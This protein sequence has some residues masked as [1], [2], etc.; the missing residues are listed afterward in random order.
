M[1]LLTHFK[2]IGVENLLC[3]G[4]PASPVSAGLVV[5][6]VVLAPHWWR[7]VLP[8]FRLPFFPLQ[9][10]GHDICHFRAHCYLEKPCG[11]FWERMPKENKASPLFSQQQF[12]FEGKKNMVTSIH[13][14]NSGPVSCSS[15]GWVEFCVHITRLLCI[16]RENS[17]LEH[18]VTCDEAFCS[19][20]LWNNTTLG[21]LVVQPVV[22]SPLNSIF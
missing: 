1:V 8:C 17:L 7:S 10:G 21:F 3:K 6:A 20:V 22:V 18:L 11:L 13:G 9:W 12:A 2:E 4:F 14:I 19:H 5:V 15:K 16:F